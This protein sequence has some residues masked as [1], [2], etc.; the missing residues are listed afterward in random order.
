MS[1]FGNEIV[2]L[3][4]PKVGLKYFSRLAK[5]VYPAAATNFPE[6]VFTASGSGAQAFSFDDYTNFPWDSALVTWAVLT[7]VSTLG[8]AGPAG[9]TH[10]T[11][12]PAHPRPHDWDT[13]VGPANLALMFGEHAVY[14]SAQTPTAGDIAVFRS[15][16]VGVVT[17]YDSTHQMLTIID[18]S[19]YPLDQD[20]RVFSR[21]KHVGKIRTFVRFT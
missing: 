21:K 6:Q 20:L 17:A 12:P 10:F 16:H 5:A 19:R 3:L 4:T 14:T 13:K 15:Q 1:T 2:T 18:G 7:A 11:N 9:L 8:G